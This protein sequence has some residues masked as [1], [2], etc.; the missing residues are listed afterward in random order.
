MINKYYVLLNYVF[1]DHAAL[2]L[3]IKSI[4]TGTLKTQF[5]QAIFT[6]AL[7]LSSIYFVTLSA[8]TLLVLCKFESKKNNDY[9]C[10]HYSQALAFAE[11]TTGDS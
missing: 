1:Y 3:T 6:L 2:K 11:N 4:Q 9:Y 5:N 10:I 8:I 7:S